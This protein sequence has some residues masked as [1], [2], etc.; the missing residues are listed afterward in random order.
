MTQD[1]LALNLGLERTQA[2][3][4]FK[5]VTGQTF[6]RF[7]KWAASVTVTSFVFDGQVIGQAGMDAGFSDAAHTSRTVKELFGLTPTDGVKSL[8]GIATLVR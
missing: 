1:E 2:L 7:K 8:R 3:K 6:R 4:Y 5:S